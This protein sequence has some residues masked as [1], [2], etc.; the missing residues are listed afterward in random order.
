VKYNMDVGPSYICLHGI[1][2]CEVLFVEH[3]YK[4]GHD[5]TL[6][7]YIRKKKMTLALQNQYATSINCS[8]EQNYTRIIKTHLWEAEVQLYSFLT[9]ALDAGEC[10]TSR[11]GRFIAG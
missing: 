5:T 1:H 3:H 10:S 4:H 6:R 2:V 9:S 11:H 7:N 8:K